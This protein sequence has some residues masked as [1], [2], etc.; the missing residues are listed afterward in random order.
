MTFN[1]PKMS[2]NRS[3]P[4]KLI[5]VFVLIS[6]N[7]LAQ[8]RNPIDYPSSDKWHD[9]PLVGNDTI[10]KCMKYYFLSNDTIFFRE[11]K[12]EAI[13]KLALSEISQTDIY[14]GKDLQFNAQSNIS[15]P[16]KKNG[17]L[18]GQNTERYLA[19]YQQAIPVKYTKQVLA[20]SEINPIES[21]PESSTIANV[22]EPS[23]SQMILPDSLP[24]F[25][26]N[27]AGFITKEGC[28]VLTYEYIGWSDSRY[29][30]SVGSKKQFFYL[31][32]SEVLYVHAL[33]LAKQYHLDNKWA[34]RFW[35][36]SWRAAVV[37]CG[38]ILIAGAASLVGYGSSSAGAMVGTG[39]IGL[40]FFV[41]VAQD[42]FKR[43]KRAKAHKK[44]QHYVCI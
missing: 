32:T 7:A 14:Y 21:K 5:F 44:A 6:S 9:L 25:L 24:K 39:A 26:A 19:Y 40:G 11:A 20:K 28:K 33:N 34:P 22:A 30:F 16:R 12:S 8:Q 38:P 43:A 10:I 31:D 41:L 15:L 3:I 35:S 29:Y 1:L 17:D 13:Y 18:K 2:K 37:V 42:A 36:A 4:L 27:E 23:S